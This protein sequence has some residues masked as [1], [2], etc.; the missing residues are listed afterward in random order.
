M[1]AA[2]GVTGGRGWSDPARPGCPARFV[3][4]ALLA[5]HA[6]R[7]LVAVLGRPWAR[8]LGVPGRLGADH[9]ARNPQRT[10]MTSAALTVG[11]A[12]VS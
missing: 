3:G 7:P 6:V 11:L 10:V 1:L 4:L 12:L 2:A 9:A 8:L 5:R